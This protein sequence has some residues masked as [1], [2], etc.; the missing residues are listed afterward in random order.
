MSLFLAE[1]LQ[2]SEAEPASYSDL[3]IN[4]QSLHSGNWRF[5]L[6]ARKF[7]RQT[8][9]G[10]REARG[11][12]LQTQICGL[13]ARIRPMRA[14]VQVRPRAGRAL[15]RVSQWRI[16]RS[17]GSLV[18]CRRRCGRG[19]CP[20][21]IPI[22]GRPLGC[23]FKGRR[24]PPCGPAWTRMSMCVKCRYF[25]AFS[26]TI[27]ESSCNIEDSRWGTQVVSGS[28]PAIESDSESKLTRP[29]LARRGRARR[30]GSHAGQGQ[31]GPARASIPG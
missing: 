3:Y 25:A 17:R 7:R 19:G 23:E 12:W 13:W 26:C 28:G 6:Q 10:M 27:N 15:A 18:P 31:H 2:D 14:K 9:A 20:S 16:A 24:R 30:A 5:L 29:P 4:L 8:V 11:S 21:P 22:R 1:P